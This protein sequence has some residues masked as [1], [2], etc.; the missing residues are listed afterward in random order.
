MA[1]SMVL[2]CSSGGVV[3]S[4]SF[5][6]TRLGRYAS[7]CTAAQVL[8]GHQMPPETNWHSVAQGQQ[9]RACLSHNDAGKWEI[10]PGG[11]LWQVRGCQGLY[12]TLSAY[13]PCRC[14]HTTSRVVWLSW[15]ITLLGTH[16]KL[17]NIV[18]WSTAGLLAKQPRTRQVA[19]GLRWIWME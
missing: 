2:Y 5:S 7:V 14:E 11:T 6:V 8:R 15:Y 19:R 12:R 4:D 10:R 3:S 9:S 17:M 16:V 13:L 1:Q 18:R